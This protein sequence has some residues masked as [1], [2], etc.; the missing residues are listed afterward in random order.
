[1]SD[2]I[3]PG[4]SPSYQVCKQIYEYH[5]LGAKMAESPIKL[6]QSQ[7]RDITVAK[8]PE[9]RVKEAFEAEW[10]RI[11][12]DQIIFNTIKTAR[13]YGI[14]SVASLVDGMPT[15]Q[16]IDPWSLPDV[17]ISFNVFDPLN[18]SGSLVLNQN[19]N[20]RD[21]QKTQSIAVQGRVYHRSR[22]R[23]V[24]NEDPV[25]IG[26]TTSAFGYVGRS[27]YQRALFPLKSFINTMVTNDMV[28]LKAGLIVAKIKQPGSIVDQAMKTLT[29]IKRA[30]LKEA[31]VGNVLSISPDEAIESLNLQNLDGAYGAAR[32]FI[33]KDIATAAD[34]PAVMIENETLTE[35]FG[36]GTEDAKNIAR[37][38]DGIRIQAAGLYEFFD[39]IVQHRAWSPEFYKTIQADFPEYRGRPYKRAFYDWANSFTAVWPNLLK[40][41]DSEAVKTEDV[42]LKALIASVEVLYPALD[43]EN[44]VNLVAWFADNLNANKMMFGT[45]LVIDLEALENYEPPQMQAL[46][47]PEEPKPFAAADS[48]SRER[49]LRRSR[50]IAS[51]LTS[52][53]EQ[54]G[55]RL[56]IA[57]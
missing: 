15:D 23:I 31:Q 43:P 18:T 28:S 56:R 17:D 32:K 30:I 39:H 37:Y 5:P 47:E 29:G 45:P 4:A 54:A 11:G 2:E 50:N 27:V 10:K 13:M 53:V 38:I 24:L 51:Y 19:P 22:C 48:D 26:Y 21:F 9:E 33:L 16:P 12:A 34:M 25:Y 49:R 3:V 8:G 52:K 41:P 42:K 6:A 55:G 35:G 7:K 20:E 1:M 14:A 46:V 40:E 36:E 44:K 57:G